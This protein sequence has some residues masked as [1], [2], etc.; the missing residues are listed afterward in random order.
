MGSGVQP[1]G[2]PRLP[3][4]GTGEAPPGAASAARPGPERRVRVPGASLRGGGAVAVGGVG[5][6]VPLPGSPRGGA[7]CP[8]RIGSGE[9]KS[10]SRA[11]GGG[12][13]SL[14]A[15]VV[16]GCKRARRQRR[17]RRVCA[18]GA[19]DGC[20][21]AV[22]IE[23]GVICERQRAGWEMGFSGWE[24]PL[25]NSPCKTSVNFSLKVKEKNV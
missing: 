16:A 22:V 25:A 9:R 20:F 15:L 2:T 1:P 4:R 13:R 5:P 10:H 6:G 8:V 21:I 7:L 18:L 12:P 17:E 3:S 23:D 14:R 24:S 11:G 19:M